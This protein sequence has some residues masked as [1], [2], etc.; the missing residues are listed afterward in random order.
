MESSILISNFPRQRCFL[1]SVPVKLGNRLPFFFPPSD[2]FPRPFFN[3]SEDQEINN[4]YKKKS[5]KGAEWRYLGREKV[6]KSGINT[7]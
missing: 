3:V 7:A 2:A 1:N 5:E 6:K 4:L